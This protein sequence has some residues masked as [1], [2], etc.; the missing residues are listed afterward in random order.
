MLASTAQVDLKDR[1][2]NIVKLQKR[3][4]MKEVKVLNPPR[5]G[6]KCL[7]RSGWTPAQLSNPT[8]RTRV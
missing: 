8:N 3:V 4:A 6:K 2:V 7:V 1:E 5:E